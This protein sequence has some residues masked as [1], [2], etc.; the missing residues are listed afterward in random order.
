L[1]PGAY[2]HIP[3]CAHRCA[4]CSF[5]ALEGRSEERDFF[6]GVEREIRSRA[7]EASRGVR[8]F[9]SVY[10]GG[11]TPSYVDA[12]RLGRLLGTLEEV[13]GVSPDAEI[14]AEANP[15]DLTRARLL[16]LHAIGVN[17][18]SVGVQSLVDEDLEPLE[19]RH[20]A[21][22]ALS[23]LKMAVPLFGN[24]SADLM[25]GI[26]GQ[27][28]ASLRRSVDGLL[29]TGVRHLS[30]YLLEIEKAPR[31]LRLLSDRPDLFADD[32]EMAARWEMVDDLCTAAGLPRYEISNWARPGFES[33]H[34]LKYWT[35]APT[36]GFG[37]AA[38][39]F[40]GR[41][42]S[43]NTGSLAG[44]IERTRRGESPR[45]FQEEET[46]NSLRKK[47]GLMLGLR[48]SSGVPA[49]SFEEISGTLPAAEASRVWDAF[50]AGLLEVVGEGRDRRVRLTRRGVLLS[51]EV[52]AHF[53]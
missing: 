12:A 30:I 4:Y 39:S 2:V 24:V 32:D 38:H 36:L 8:N 29:E 18:L 45:V 19:R 42:R 53:L 27:T 23:A 26:P 33:R 11:G 1:T 10:F 9:D 34:N 40:D 28:R 22:A 25:I 49:F 48:L 47:E 46:G 6:E 41:R 15:D 5:V 13:F 16:E 44:F 21:A 3:F 37:V 14:T 20:D 52:F 7:G 31:L 43:A 50:D 35:M 51:N 17:R